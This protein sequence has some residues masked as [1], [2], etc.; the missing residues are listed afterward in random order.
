M[1]KKNKRG[2]PLGSGDKSRVILGIRVNEIQYNMVNKGLLKLKEKCKTNKKTILYLFK[3]YTLTHKEREIGELILKIL[4]NESTKK[5]YTEE[6]KKEL[7]KICEMI[8]SIGIKEIF[9]N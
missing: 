9:N 4:T 3:N 7:I 1:E 2:R 8:K 6:E 5:R